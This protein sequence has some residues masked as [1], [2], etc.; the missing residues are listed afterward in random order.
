MPH[1]FKKSDLLIAYT[2]GTIDEH[3]GTGNFD[4]MYERLLVTLAREQ[5]DRVVEAEQDGKHELDEALDRADKIDS[6]F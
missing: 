6:I 5:I 3:R 1:T 4:S 2:A